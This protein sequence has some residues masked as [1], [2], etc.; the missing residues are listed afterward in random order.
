MLSK[1]VNE[2]LERVGPGEA[3][4]EVFRRFW[5]PA[6]LA[7]EVPAPDSPPVRV[8][9]LGEDLVAFRDSNGK[10]GIFDAYCAHR[11]AP[12]FFGRNEEAGLRCIYHGWKFDVTGQCVDMP[13]CLEGESFKDK[14]NVKAYP[15]FEG[16]N[17]VWVYMGPADRVP[18]KPGFEWLDLP[19]DHVYVTKY[20]VQCNYLQT[21]ENEFDIGHSSFLH[22]TLHPS[23]SQ[24]FQIMGRNPPIRPGR[25]ANTEVYD[26]PYG[27]AAGR[28]TED[29]RLALS[30]HFMLP[31]FSSAGAV[32]AP[33]TNP[34]NLKIPVDDAN[35]VFF[36]MKWSPEP[37]KP[38]VLS[39]YLYGKHEFPERIPGTYLTKANKSNDYLQDRAL[40]R[41]FNYS[42]MN[43]Y[44]V[45][46]FAMV[47]DQRGPIA[48]RSRET[49][50]S[51]DTYIIHMRRKLLEA[52]KRVI[53]G[54]DLEQPWH[55]EAFHGI[56][57]FH[58]LS[59]E[60][61]R[62]QVTLAV[63]ARKAPAQEIAAS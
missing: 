24:S 36:R 6:V 38:E 31:S 57:N 40:Q 18:P 20:Y 26:T 2:L 25:I 60:E 11:N 33:N 21:L 61:E 59:E 12:L 35:T 43:P 14:V 27:S 23:S 50:V 56:R 58:I 53:R 51:S 48:D 16:G 1:Q 13:N 4:G 49:L 63:P 37:L 52:C 55:P 39:T 9:L 19:P 45:Q 34:L 29:G 41:N 28:R 7:E 42:G 46:D 8:R 10:V 3:M 47:E 62:N 15:T 44:P 32:S 54:E 17:M 22:S 5:L 30:A